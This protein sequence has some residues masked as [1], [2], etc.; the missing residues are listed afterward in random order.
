MRQVWRGIVNGIEILAAIGGGVLVLVLVILG[1]VLGSDRGRTRLADELEIRL[2]SELGLPIEIGAL[3]FHW[4]LHLG[5]HAVE[6]GSPGGGPVPFLRLDAVQVALQ[7]LALMHREV[8]VRSLEIDGPD[9]AV[10]RDASGTLDWPRF[11]HPDTTRA[12]EREGTPWRLTVH[13]LELRRGRFQLS[14]REGASPTVLDSLAVVASV[15]VALGAPFRGEVQV[16]ELAGVWVGPAIAIDRATLGLDSGPPLNGE[17][18]VSALRW[19]GVPLAIGLALDD[20]TFSLE[21]RA[22]EI[23]AGHLSRLH[24]ALSPWSPFGLE[25][26]AKGDTDVLRSGRGRVDTRLALAGVGGDIR[27][28]GPLLLGERATSRL[29]LDF[30]GL[31]PSRFH[32]RAPSGR[33]AGSGAISLTTGPGGRIPTRARIDLDLRQSELEGQALER[34]HLVIGISRQG[35]VIDDVALES[36]ADRVVGHLEIGRGQRLDGD[37]EVR[38]GD[39]ARWRDLTGQDL[40]GDCSAQITIRGYSNALQVDGQVAARDLRYAD[41]VTLAGVRG[42]IELTRND[43]V[44]AGRTTLTADSL[45]AGDAVRLADVDAAVSLDGGHTDI[46]LDARGAFLSVLAGGPR[47]LH[48]G[49]QATREPEGTSAIQISAFSLGD[50]ARLTAPLEIRRHGP[51]LAIDALSLV[52][53]GATI[54]GSGSRHLQRTTGTLTFQQADVSALR[55]LLQPVWPDSGPLAVIEGVFA[56]ELEAEMGPDQATGRIDLEA[57]DLR[58]P[59][60]L[61]ASAPPLSATLQARLDPRELAGTFALEGDDL[62]SLG[63]AFSLPIT[64]DGAK[65]RVRAGEG[66]LTVTSSA[67]ADSLGIYLASDRPRFPAT[68]AASAITLAG[69]FGGTLDQPSGRMDL[70]FVLPP[71]PRFPLTSGDLDLTLGGGRLALDG[72]LDVSGSGP[73][74]ASIEIPL[75]VDLREQRL[76]IVRDGPLTGDL[77]VAALDLSALHR[78]VPA[79]VD[80]H[81]IVDLD[82][83]VGGTFAA[84]T[85][86]G[87]LSLVRGSLDIR[88]INLRFRDLHLDAAFDERLLRVVSAGGRTAGG[89]VAISGALPMPRATGE[90]VALDIQADGLNLRTADG[91][92][93]TGAVNLAVSGTVFRPRIEGSLLVDEAE[94]PVPE[95][96]RQKLIAVDD[97]EAGL[98]DSRESRPRT[99]RQLPFDLDIRI[100]MPR[101]I[102][103]RNKQIAVEISGD[104]ELV[105]SEEGLRLLGQLESKRGTVR[106]V[107]RV[108]TVTQGEVTFYGTTQINPALDVEAE[109][110]VS[111]TRVILSLLGTARAPTFELSSE[112]PLP[113]A[114]II[115]L[116]LFGKDSSELSL[117]ERTMVGDRA[118]QIAT[119]MTAATVADAVGSQLG[120]DVAQIE[121]SGAHE[122]VTVGKYLS[123]QAL[124]RVYQELGS[125]GIGG[126]VIEYWLLPQI[127]IEVG[128][129]ADGQTTLDVLWRRR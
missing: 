41:R 31:D 55:S 23:P 69:T 42:D 111:D 9:V 20:E 53:A 109:I 108:F 106:F 96:R 128:A 78:Y 100:Q 1:V 63:V 30:S 64:V 43:G 92:K 34:G 72:R 60:T 88:P 101:R 7:P 110:Q 95:R 65:L 126:V 81:G 84:P 117:D 70:R 13:H 73:A 58:W 4:P 36:M 15:A 103:L 21:I 39:L 51:D 47:P 50:A 74:R 18:T 121:T 98:S 112:P 85:W 40:H 123:S 62:D 12:E 57:R 67:H 129:S 82:A 125:G 14:G 25:A 6:V 105:T 19:G 5:L 102:W 35:V 44:L 93:A 26:S 48:A 104:L 38:V 114:D 56:G 118:G 66:P 80:L 79:A 37:F 75:S 76:S 32:P 8:R 120:L 46:V 94:I 10:G 52:L 124:V 27:I 122:R 68:L 113:E 61:S 99:T 97:D 59:G 90:T 127:Q 16:D 115:S 91:L 29:R 54:S 24:R 2:S 119:M 116:L 71:E 107:D 49:L 28:A 86:V 11:G 22:R 3:E 77:L 33:L 83:K 45:F 89:R 17:L 87:A